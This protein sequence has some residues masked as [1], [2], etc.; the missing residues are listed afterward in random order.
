MNETAIANVR[1]QL[2][3][4]GTVYC[5]YLYTVTN[6]ENADFHRTLFLTTMAFTLPTAIMGV[7]YL[8]W[9]IRFQVRPF[10][11]SLPFISS[12]AGKSGGQS[13]PI[14]MVVSPKP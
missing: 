12:F 11:F 1:P 5:D 9:K 4:N 10:H 14:T 8:S 6:C 7:I 3:V 2:I 13:G